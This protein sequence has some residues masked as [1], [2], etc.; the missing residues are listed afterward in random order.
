MT[1][2]CWIILGVVIAILV[3]T[4]IA[5]VVAV[6]VDK[7]GISHDVKPIDFYLA[8]SHDFTLTSWNLK[9]FPI[10]FIFYF[11]NLSPWNPFFFL[12][13]STALRNFLIFLGNSKKSKYSKGKLLNYIWNIATVIQYWSST[14]LEWKSSSCMQL[15]Q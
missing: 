15:T 10:L 14:D 7:S 2:R 1:R 9:K 4:I 5:V 12:N 6:V 8:V 11:I 3:V 13:C